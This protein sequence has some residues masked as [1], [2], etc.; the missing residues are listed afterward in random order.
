MQNRYL[1]GSFSQ[2]QFTEA[3]DFFFQKLC[4]KI[5]LDFKDPASVRALTTVLLKQDFNLS[6]ELP[7]NRLVPTLPLRLNYLLWIEDL[8]ALMPAKSGTITGLDIGAGAC[9]I[10]SI[11][12]A[13]KNGWHFT[14]TEA[15]DINYECS[16]KTI[17]K[18]NLSDFIML[19]KVERESLLMG[20]LIPGVLY[21]FTMC[22]PPFFDSENMEQKSRTEKRHAPMCPV[23]GGSTSSDE[24]AFKGGEGNTSRL[25]E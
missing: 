17:A 10:Y 16:L 7:P 20:N 13:V 15:D 9:C 12:G 2:F 6:V 1:N 25:C 14:T 3:T 4:G 22:N 23:K 24:I 21:D 5:E 18:N 11:I 19:K 8:L